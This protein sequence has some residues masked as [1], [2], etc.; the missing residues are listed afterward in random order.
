MSYHGCNQGGI[1]RMLTGTNA[2]FT[3]PLGV[4]KVLIGDAVY[5]YLLGN[6]SHPGAQGE[7]EPVI[8]FAAQMSRDD[9][10]QC[11]GGDGLGNPCLYQIQ[12]VTDIDRHEDISRGLRALAFDS[13]N[14]TIF[15]KDSI[16][17]NAGLVCKR[18]EQGNNELWLTRSEERSVGRGG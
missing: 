16:D 17:L 11:L 18:L 15:D 10:G 1:I 13:L 4:R 7:G 8:I 9:L 5:L 12:Q 2:D 6:I 14:Q 3:L